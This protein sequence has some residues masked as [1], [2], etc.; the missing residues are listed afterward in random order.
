VRRNELHQ[1]KLDQIR[2]LKSQKKGPRLT[3]RMTLKNRLQICD[4]ERSAR[5]GA[6]AFAKWIESMGYSQRDAA[7]K[8]NMQSGTLGGWQRR[9]KD[10]HLHA[11][12]AGR[13]AIASDRDTRN[14][15]VALFY[16]A[17][18]GIGMPAL[19]G[20]FP[21]L[22]KGE[23]EDMLRRYRQVHL[24]RNKVLLHVLRWHKPGTVWAI[25][26]FDAPLPVDGIYRYVFV[27]RDLA[28]G[29]QLLA[30]PVKDKELAPAADALAAL[31]MQHGAPLVVKSDCGFTSPIIS[32]LLDRHSIFHLLSPP[33]TPQYNAA[34]EAGIGSLKTRAHHEAARH[35]HPSEWNCDDVEA[36][37]LQANELARPWGHNADTPDIAWIER[38]P[39]APDDRAAFATKVSTFELE[40][41]QEKQRYLLEG[42]PLGPRDIASARRV[43]I[44]RALVAHGLLSFRRKRFTLPIKRSIWSNVS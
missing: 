5:M 13:P 34:I 7:D 42:I 12:P 32:G 14:L 4:Y 8:L 28:S 39:I 20:F 25:D 17:G 3:R 40:E 22:P 15:I 2:E 27:V 16:I 21:E 19:R 43:A 37:R 1:Q 26:F 11:E 33:Y 10:N 29:N 18:P 35:G 44:S 31:I 23:L 6:L 9:W 24:S 41:R 36:A 30:L 38:Q